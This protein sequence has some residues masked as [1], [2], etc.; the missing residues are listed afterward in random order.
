MKEQFPSGVNI[1]TLTNPKVANSL[2]A[3]NKEG[4]EQRSGHKFYAGSRNIL[5][6][7]DSDSIF[8]RDRTQEADS[9]CD[10]SHILGRSN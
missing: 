1:S 9:E 4:S 3:A 8:P 6:T 5:Q 2:F 10:E 7:L